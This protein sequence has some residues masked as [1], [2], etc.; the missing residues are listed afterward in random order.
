MIEIDKKI[1][2][3]YEI[4]DSQ[5]NE[6]FNYGIT[7]DISLK[8]LVSNKD[9][10]DIKRAFYYVLDCDIGI[11]ID[12]LENTDINI[13]DILDFKE[14][15]AVSD[16]E[17]KVDNI[18]SSFLSVENGTAI[19]DLERILDGS[20]NGRKESLIYFKI[21]PKIKN[22]EEVISSSTVLSI[23]D[24][25]SYNDIRVNS[26][27]FANTGAHPDEEL[28]VSLGSSN[29]EDFLIQLNSN[30]NGIISFLIPSGMNGS[31]IINSAF[32]VEESTLYLEKSEVNFIINSPYLVSKH[33]SVFIIVVQGSEM[34]SGMWEWNGSQYNGVDREVIIDFDKNIGLDKVF[35][36]DINQDIVDFR[37]TSHICINY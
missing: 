11:L 8:T 18:L 26:L 34:V 12:I 20:D 4:N 35:L 19:N 23:L 32:S 31:K 1:R 33:F 10:D 15:I 6:I 16:P 37:S 27:S 13:D 5:V 30:K 21:P 2:R 7:Q 9:I 3:L 36:Q 22:I 17:Y 25:D 24:V 14:K 29:M 28:Y